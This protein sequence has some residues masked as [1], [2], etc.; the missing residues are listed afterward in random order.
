MKY[1]VEQKLFIY[2]SSYNILHERNAIENFIEAV[3]WQY[4]AL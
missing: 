1:T 2:K 4:S 3:A